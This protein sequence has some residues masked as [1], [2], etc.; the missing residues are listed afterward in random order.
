MLHQVTV[1]NAASIG[2]TR[3]L[4]TDCFDK[5]PTCPAH[6]YLARHELDSVLIIMVKGGCA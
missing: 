5:T 6:T 4:R 1:M 2:R 3:M